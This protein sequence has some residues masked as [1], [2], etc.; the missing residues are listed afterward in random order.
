VTSALLEV[1][2]LRIALG[3]VPI[4]E[5]FALSVLEGQLHA[6]LGESGSGK[7]I[8][9][10]AMLGLLPAPLRALGGRLRFE[11]LEVHAT[12]VRALARLRGRGIAMV[13]QDPLLALNPVRSIVDQVAE[14][15]RV[16]GKLSRREARAGAEALLA[17]VGLER[18]QGRE[19]C[20]PHQLSGGMRQRALLAAALA[21]QPRVLIADEP[22]SALDAPLRLVVLA[23]LRRV[24]SRRRL[25]VLCITHDVAWVR[26]GCSFVSVLYAGRIVEQGPA[27]QVLDA[28]LHP[29]TRGLLA[30]RPTAANRGRTLGTLF[31][32]QPSPA[33]TIVGC[34]FH[35]RCPNAFP[36]C[37][38]A[39]PGLRALEVG[40]AVA[41]HE[42]MG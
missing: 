18:V 30:S 12:D 25:G 40:S 10:R 9:A 6:L 1:A 14:T 29:Y 11:G 5:G 23:L 24:A 22:T 7:T 17:E 38:Q 2:D 32:T 3:E 37:R 21:G 26:A 34:R 15:V 28:P 19:A 31:G 41:C 42:V 20:F 33:E 8:A 27:E 36:R 39:A 16:H 13:P 35:P 4:V